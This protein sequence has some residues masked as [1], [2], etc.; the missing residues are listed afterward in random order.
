[1]K[2]SQETEDGICYVLC[3]FIKL[4]ERGQDFFCYV[5][6]DKII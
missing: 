1:V 5:C 2:A 3:V 4:C 6:V